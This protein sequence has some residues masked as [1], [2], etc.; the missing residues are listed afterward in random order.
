MKKFSSLDLKKFKKIQASDIDVGNT[1]ILLLFDSSKAFDLI[2]HEI[3]LNELFTCGYVVWLMK[4]FLLI[5]HLVNSTYQEV[6]VTQALN[7]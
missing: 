1:L 4:G 5:H 3:L 6:T 7:P 2:D